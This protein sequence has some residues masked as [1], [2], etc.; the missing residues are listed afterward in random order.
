MTKKIT[1]KEMFEII[2]NEL[3]G[4]SDVVEFCDKEIAALARKAAKAKEKAA[5][6]KAQ[7]DALKDTVYSL[8]TNELQTI[9]DITG[10]IEG[11]DVTVAKVSYRLTA[12]TKAGAAVKEEVSIETPEGKKVKRAAYKLV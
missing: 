11:E 5:E 1:K 7:G 12:L 6:K 2:K 3:A 8:L 4:N 10:Q 9:S